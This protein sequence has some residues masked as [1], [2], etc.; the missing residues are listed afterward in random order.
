MAAGQADLAIG[1]PPEDWQGPV[2]TADSEEFVVVTHADDQVARGQTGRVLLGDLAARRWVHFTPDGGLAGF[3]DRAC[4]AA[5]FQGRIA[6]RT[7]QGMSAANYAAAGL[8]PTLIPAEI[9]PPHFGG[10]C[11]S[12]TRRSAAR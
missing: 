10:C 5:G 12:P 7:E 6:V 1:P 3:L 9:I 4:A 2:R 8:G 11:C